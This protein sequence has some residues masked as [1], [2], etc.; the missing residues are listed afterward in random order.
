MSGSAQ[1]NWVVF[2]NSPP[3]SEV[4]KLAPDLVVRGSSDATQLLRRGWS[5]KSPGAWCKG[6]VGMTQS[7]IERVCAQEASAIDYV[8]EFTR[9]YP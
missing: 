9:R 8:P 1:T 6:F 3:E 2:G 7:D 4:V 5:P